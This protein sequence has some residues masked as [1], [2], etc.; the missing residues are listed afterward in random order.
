M[1]RALF[2]VLLLSLPGLG[3]SASSQ[4]QPF[5]SYVFRHQPPSSASSGLPLSLSLYAPP[6]LGNPKLMYRR[7]D[8]HRFKSVPFQAQPDGYYIAVVP[9]EDVVAPQLQYYIVIDAPGLPRH[10]A[11]G[12]PENP[13]T[14][15]V[16]GGLNEGQEL[17]R[18]GYRDEVNVMAESVQYP[19]EAGKGP[20]YYY[21]YEAE[22]LY[23]VFGPIYS[24]RF[25]T[26]ELKGQSNYASA[27]VQV[28]NPLGQVQT[29]KVYSPEN[30]GFLY[31]YLEAE[32]RSQG[33]GSPVSFINRVI[34]G[35]ETDGT[36]AGWQ[37]RIRI[38][39]ELGVNFVAGATLISDMGDE[40]FAE[41][42]IR[43]SNNTF[44]TLASHVENLPLNADLG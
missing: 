26:G 7:G 32:I 30:I 31:S 17:K 39:D 38:G 5:D 40:G 34:L 3:K 19:A 41:F 2:L 43:P 25:G 29:E 6:P 37:G 4:A 13:V 33:L 12:N 20:D 36:G 15:G 8:E 24:F 1:M 42:N 44:V 18:Y 27:S 23:R 35:T 9:A 16:E 28:T 14:V 10:L 21:R 11:V 22:Y